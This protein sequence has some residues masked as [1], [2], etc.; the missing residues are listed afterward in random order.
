MKAIPLTQNKVALVDDGDFE[1]VSVYRWHAQRA[2]RRWYAKR[3]ILRADGGQT[4]QCLHQ[5]LLPGVKMVDHKDGNGL[6]NCRDN[7]REATKLQNQRGF[8]HKRLGTASKYRG[9]SFHSRDL[10]WVAYINVPGKR[11]NLGY[12]LTEKAA[13]RA[14][15][16]AAQLHF[17]EFASP[18]LVKLRA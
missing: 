14:Y 12:F 16:A 4:T 13:A 1:K 17:G 9:V 18:N 3:N 2:R 7:L 15:D 10:K 5:F 6:N 11:I 8:Q